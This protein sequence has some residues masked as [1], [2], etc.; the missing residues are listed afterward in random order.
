[1]E[2]YTYKMEKAKNHWEH[3]VNIPC[4]TNLKEE[5]VKRVVN[6]I[7]LNMCILKDCIDKYF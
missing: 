6:T 5:D 2:S 1:M 4:S 3:V 7:I